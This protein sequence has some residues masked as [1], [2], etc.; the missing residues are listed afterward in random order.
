MR[1]RCL[2]F[3]PVMLIFSCKAKTIDPNKYGS[4]LPPLNEADYR[5]NTSAFFPESSHNLWR[6]SCQDTETTSP[7]MLANP[8]SQTLKLESP[9]PP[10]PYSSRTY[11]DIGANW[12]E[13]FVIPWP[14]S[15]GVKE[16]PEKISLS[17]TNYAIYCALE[18]NG[19][20]IVT[21][22]LHTAGA[23][24]RDQDEGDMLNEMKY[25]NFKGWRNPV[26]AFDI[27]GRDCNAT[28]VRQL[29][30]G[31]KV[32]ESR[33]FTPT[34]KGTRI[35]DFLFENETL[36]VVGS[37]GRRVAAERLDSSLDFADFIR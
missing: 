35:A 30:D 23:F 1:F 8:L 32:R 18:K 14:D 9:T 26:F 33:S 5:I 29:P 24:I 17:K 37:D 28:A 31:S 22:T 21:C 19:D 12:V 2:F 27:T 34:A 20:G 3:I 25:C 11:I 16:D 36:Y 15:C 4:P 6:L 7:L 13:I 10:S